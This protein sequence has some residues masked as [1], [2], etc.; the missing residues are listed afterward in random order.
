[1]IAYSFACLSVKDDLYAKDIH[2]LTP[3]GG[4]AFSLSVVSVGRRGAIASLVTV[5]HRTQ[6]IGAKQELLCQQTPTLALGERPM[7]L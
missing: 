4:H 3:P 2:F 6:T 7:V 1:M 5:R